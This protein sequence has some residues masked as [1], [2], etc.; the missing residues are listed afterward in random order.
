[1][2]APRS[3]LEWLKRCLSVP[4]I[5]LGPSILLLA[6]YGWLREG[7]TKGPGKGWGAREGMRGGVIED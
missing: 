7:G 3:G 6:L 2:W 5:D 1:M 4:D